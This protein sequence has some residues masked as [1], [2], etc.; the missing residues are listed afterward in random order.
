MA[1]TYR[2]DVTLVTTQDHGD[3][4]STVLIAHDLAEGETVEALVRRLLCQWDVYGEVPVPTFDDRIELR[5]AR[6]V[7]DDAYLSQMQVIDN[8]E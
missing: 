8:D 5:V 3:H 2:I 4:T 7:S 6:P 1:D